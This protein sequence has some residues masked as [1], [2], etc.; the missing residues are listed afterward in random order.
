MLGWL[1]SLGLRNLLPAWLQSFS[2][3]Y[4]CAL[5]GAVGGIVYC[6]RA[7]Y[8]NHCVRRS[9][10]AN[11][12]IWYIIRPIVSSITGLIAF[13]FLKAG[14]LILDAKHG[15]ASNHYGFLA[16]SFVAGLNV[17]RFLMKIEY[18]A[19]AS[20]GIRPSRASEESGQ[21]SPNSPERD[22]MNDDLMPRMR[23]AA[24]AHLAR[25]GA[26]GMT[27]ALM[28]FALEVYMPGA[29]EKAA[30]DIMH[31]FAAQDPP[32]AEV[33]KSEIHPWRAVITAAGAAVAEYDAP[34]PPGILRPRRG[35][36]R[37]ARPR[38]RLAP[39]GG[40]ARRAEQG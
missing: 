23:W 8:V 10:D 26:D 16:L 5:I 17:D 22:K 9:W 14:L 25:Q 2:L 35:A 3:A 18:I 40:G 37:D 7:I 32:L 15:T 11:W 24:L 21:A 28:A 13:V 30:H 39:P 36:G 31:N 29:G 12:T 20:W 1:A 6:L 34:A 19:Q 27:D 4:Q 33:E 38:G